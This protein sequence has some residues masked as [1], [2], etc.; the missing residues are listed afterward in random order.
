MIESN[1]KNIKILKEIDIKINLI[2]FKT[3]LG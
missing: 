2:E 1:L 3:K